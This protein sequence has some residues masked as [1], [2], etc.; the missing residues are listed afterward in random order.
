MQRRGGRGRLCFSA[1]HH[2][3]G[4]MRAAWTRQARRTC[5]LTGSSWAGCVSWR[6]AGTLRRHASGATPTERPSRATDAATLP[7]GSDIWRG[8]ACA[9]A[10]RQRKR[11]ILTLSSAAAPLHL[12]VTP[13]YFVCGRHRVL[14]NV[15]K[16]LLSGSKRG[17]YHGVSVKSPKKILLLLA[18]SHAH[19]FV[20]FG[21][22]T[23]SLK[24]ISKER[25]N[26][27]SESAST[28]SS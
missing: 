9:A 24:A 13:A 11:L 3:Y 15:A 10:G 25:S 14:G 16:V 26:V 19:M 6:L 28:C 4:G 2:V 21:R 7:P 1:I 17:A 8:Q 22:S 27:P 23:S 5:C 20:S 18:S 12:C